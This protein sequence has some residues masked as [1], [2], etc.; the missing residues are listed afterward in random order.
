MKVFCLLG[1]ERSFRS[2]SPAM[3]STILKRVGIK[4]VYVPLR[5]EPNHLGQ[6]VQSLRIL[7]MAGANIAVPYKES[8]MPHLDTLSEGA[9]IIGAI[10]TIVRTGDALK[11]YNTNAIG[12]MDALENV[13]FDVTGKRALIFGTGGV[14]RAVAFILKWIRADSIVVAGR[15]ATKSRHI[16]DSVGGEAMSLEAFHDRPISADIVVNATAV[17]SADESPELASLIEGLEVPEC[18][19][20]FDLNYGRT[21]N[22]WQGFAEKRGIRFSDGLTTLAFQAKRTFALWTGIQ[23]ESEEFLKALADAPDI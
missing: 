23:V 2:K 16:A 12:V 3:F 20:V 10:N 18:E 14:A 11:G 15:N 21:Q 5:V 1:D 4:G 13:G 22:I 9:T 6:A 17:S 8:I 7:N 19:L